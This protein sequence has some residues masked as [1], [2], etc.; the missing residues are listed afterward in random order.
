[1]GYVWGQGLNVVPGGPG[2]GSA[3]VHCR[4]RLLHPRPVYRALVLTISGLD[5]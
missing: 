3:L 2:S 4:V 5:R 1:M